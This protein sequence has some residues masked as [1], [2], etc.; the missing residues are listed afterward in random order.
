LTLVL[1]KACTA[2]AEVVGMTLDRARKKRLDPFKLAVTHLAD[3]R[4]G[5]RGSVRP[6]R[7]SREGLGAGMGITLAV[8][9][10]PEGRRPRQLRSA[11]QLGSHG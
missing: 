5:S 7:P 6:G 4:H 1:S 11:R 10:R 9:V 8:K 2:R 3:R